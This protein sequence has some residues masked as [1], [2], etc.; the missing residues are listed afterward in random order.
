MLFHC[1]W[2][3][4]VIVGS[5]G[6]GMS[7]RASKELVVHRSFEI[8]KRY[9]FVSQAIYGC[10]GCS[11]GTGRLWDIIRPAFRRACRCL[12]CLAATGVF[13][14][15]PQ[16]STSW[17]FSPQ[18]FSWRRPHCSIFGCAE[19]LQCILWSLVPTFSDPRTFTCNSRVFLWT[20]AGFPLER[21]RQSIPLGS[22]PNCVTIKFR[23]F[24]FYPDKP[25]QIQA[26]VNYRDSSNPNYVHDAA[27]SWVE[28][29]TYESFQLCVAHAGHSERTFYSNAT[30]DWL[31]YQGA[32]EG[33][34]AGEVSISQ[35]WTGTNCETVQFPPVREWAPLRASIII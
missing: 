2:V 8:D 34:V 31:A 13:K 9:S 17:P 35:W 11:G 32:P 30:V 25:V 5:G 4:W 10:F 21:G 24:A 20:P 23:P 18:S 28:K 22:S 26:T 7:M 16:I 14:S 1:M 27:V 29:V 19:R 33:G 3:F 6:C 15:F 12:I